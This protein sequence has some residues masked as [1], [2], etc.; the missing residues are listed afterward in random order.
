VQYS[1][2]GVEVCDARQRARANRRRAAGPRHQN[3]EPSA[4]FR[5]EYRA[6]NP[7]HSDVTSTVYVARECFSMNW[8]A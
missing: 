7:D 2:S 4:D 1:V 3:P 6:A 8:E 5:A